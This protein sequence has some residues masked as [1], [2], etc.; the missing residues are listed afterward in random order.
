V[1][2]LAGLRER[3]N[4]GE[5][6]VEL[7]SSNSRVQVLEEMAT[8]LL[9]CVSALVLDIEELDAPR[10]RGDLDKLA[11]RLTSGGDPAELADDVAHCRRETLDFAEL[12]RRHLD[13]RD[14]ELRRIVS[15]LTDG[16]AAVSSGSAGYHQRL[17]ETSAK[18]EA[19]SKLRDLVD[20]RAAITQQVTA[21]RSAV[22]ERQ[23]QESVLTSKLRTEIDHL[24]EKVARAREDARTDPLT[25][26]TNRAAFDEELARRCAL[27]ASGSEGF[28]L[29]MVDIDHFKQINDT[30]GHPVGD[31]VLSA[32]VSYLRDRV[33]RDDMVARWGGEEFAVILPGAN[34]RVAHTKARG[35][36]ESLAKAD[37]AVD[38][39]KRLRFTISI[40]VV[41]WQTGDTPETVVARG[42][43]ALYA[44]K[45]A[46]RNRA[47]KA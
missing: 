29:L 15:V 20:V 24:K 26:A 14:A 9:G 1:S 17:L 13:T 30:Y 40:G 36:V 31:R 16:L 47:T 7:A 2:L 4:L 45:R 46:G 28:A 41:A 5:L 22:A 19:A 35:L 34:R 39:S 11:G 32:L 21:L 42:D 8:A 44:A 6:S 3:R 25:K 12:E 27:A 23:Q 38:A 18:F 37:W 43:E 33:R 10:L